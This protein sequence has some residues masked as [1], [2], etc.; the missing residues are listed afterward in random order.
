MTG[1]VRWTR[2]PFCE[3]CDMPMKWDSDEQMFECPE[4]QDIV[5]AEELEEV[6][7]D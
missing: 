4:C 6:L 5:P 7:Q 2:I 3:S 1:M